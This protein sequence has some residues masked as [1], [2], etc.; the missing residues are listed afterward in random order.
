MSNSKTKGRVGLGVV[1]G[2]LLII[3]SI[4]SVASGME[5]ARSISD[6]QVVQPARMYSL[7][8]HSVADTDVIVSYNLSK[9]DMTV[10]ITDSQG[11]DEVVTSGYPSEENVLLAMTETSNGSA[12]WTPSVEGTYYIIFMMF[13][14]VANLDA[15][16][17]YTGGEPEMM[18][19]GIISLILGTATALMDLLVKN[20]KSRKKNSEAGPPE[21]SDDPPR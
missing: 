10:L 3:F 9:G 15:S 11:H 13:S 20:M 21:G 19:M 16:V 14:E 1:V 4:F 8:F 18:Q 2:I 6:E 12:V 7:V 17:S 5:Y